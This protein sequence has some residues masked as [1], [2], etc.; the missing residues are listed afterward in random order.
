[1]ISVKD[2]YECF[3][4]TWTEAI[5]QPHYTICELGLKHIC[6]FIMTSKDKR[7][8]LIEI[9]S[10]IGIILPVLSCD[11]WSFHKGNGITTLVICTVSACHLF[12]ASNLSWGARFLRMKIFVNM[13]STRYTVSTRE[14]CHQAPRIHYYRLPNW[15]RAYIDVDIIVAKIDASVYTS[16]FKSSCDDYE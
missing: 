8:L 7:D 1:M 2:I 12:I 13:I 14:S 11:S 3:L 4:R 9:V 16:L 5:W 6:F 15:W 10:K